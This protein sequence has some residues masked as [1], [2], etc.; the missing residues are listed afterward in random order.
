[1]HAD[2]FTAEIVRHI[3][4]IVFGITIPNADEKLYLIR[5]VCAFVCHYTEN[6][7][8]STSTYNFTSDFQFATMNELILGQW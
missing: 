8:L 1:M 5:A 4:Y 3:A 6:I 7:G 2:I